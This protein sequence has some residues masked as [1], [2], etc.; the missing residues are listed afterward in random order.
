MS[1][2]PSISFGG[3]SGGNGSGEPPEWGRIIGNIEAQADLTDALEAKAPLSAGNTAKWGQISGLIADQPDLLALIG[4]DNPSADL[5]MFEFS[6]GAISNAVSAGVG[7]DYVRPPSSFTILGWL[8]SVYSPSTNGPV[9]FD[10]SVNRLS[11]FGAQKIQIDQDEKSSKTASVQAEGVFINVFADSEMTVDIDAAGVGATGWK[12]WVFGLRSELGVAPAKP[13]A[14]ISPPTITGTG[15]V[16]QTL[17]LTFVGEWANAPIGYTV[18]WLRNGAVV[19]WVSGTTYV[20]T[21]EDAGYDI[22]ARV[23]ASNGGGFASA[24]SN[25]IYVGL[26]VPENTAAPS[27]GVSATEGIQLTASAGTWRYWPAS[28][29]YFWRSRPT[30]ADAWVPI[31]GAIT[32]KYTPPPLFVGHQLSVGVQATNVT[33]SSAIVYSAPVTVQASRFSEFW[34]P[35]PV[36]QSTWDDPT[37]PLVGSHAT[38]NVGPGKTYAEVNDV[39]WLSLVAGDVVNIFYRPTAYKAKIGMWCQGTESQWVVVHG[40]MDGSGNMPHIDGSGATTMTD[41]ISPD[42]IIEPFFSAAYTENLGVIYIT[43]RFLMGVPVKPKYI[44]IENLK[45]TGGG[46]GNSFTDQFGNTRTYGNGTGG[47]FALVSEHLTIRNC[48]ITDNGNGVFTNTKDDVEDYA[49]YYTTIEGCKIYDNG[50]VGSYYEHN[51]YVQSVRALYQGNY[52]GRL[53]PGALGSSLKDRSSGTVVRFNEINAAARALDLVDSEGGLPSVIADPMYRYAWVYGNLITN[54]LHNDHTRNGSGQMIHWSG[55]NDPSTYRNGTLFFYNNTVIII[56]DT[57]DSYHVGVFDGSSDRSVVDISYNVFAKYGSAYMHL[58]GAGFP[59]NM[60]GTNWITSGWSPAWSGA[61]TLNQYGTLLEGADPGLSSVDYAIIEGSPLINGGRATV[62]APIPYVNAEALR[63]DY[64]PGATHGTYIP[65]PKL[66]VEYDIGCFETATGS[67]AP[68]P[69]PPPS[70]LEPGVDRVFYFD[71]ANGLSITTINYKW[72]GATSDYV[73]ANTGALRLADANLWTSGRIR[74]VDGQGANQSAEMVRRGQ[75]WG[76]SAAGLRLVL[77]DD[78][79]NCY[80]AEMGN[81][82]WQIYRNGSWFA[83]GSGLSIDWTANVKLTFT[84]ASGVLHFYLN[85]SALNGA[86]TTD[87]TPLTGGYPGLQIGANGTTTGH[88]IESWTDTPV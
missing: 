17:T 34:P 28:F 84:I 40:V 4:I 51:L 27:F 1:R 49:S 13:T 24:L 7:R 9:K 68:P 39:P 70:I 76:G 43:R 87:G 31:A 74:F 11:V 29:G 20:Q 3:G 48:E 71:V 58:G 46:P 62:S 14:G 79:T 16:G 35:V 36:D 78:G 44:R 88:Y 45:V 54:D 30:P 59:M 82:T 53:R 60:R 6:G 81:S 73:T 72:A 47:I 66:G 37:V 65:R 8:A 21:P 61:A 52:I 50:V 83:G 23:T 86:G 56:A 38:Y 32:N 57:V 41:A 85:G 22:T 67:A 15:A 55:D 63:V 33:G 18:E 10:V 80:V 42:G 69:P 2:F 25:S 12:L 77:Q 75:A 19:D 26:P 64:Q 5:I